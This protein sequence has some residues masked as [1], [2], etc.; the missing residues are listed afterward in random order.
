M[1]SE[2]IYYG[3]LVVGVSLVCWEVLQILDYLE[4]KIWAWRR[5]RI[6]RAWLTELERIKNLDPTFKRCNGCG[7]RHL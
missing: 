2:W 5:G 1:S 3:V 4:R 7:L 6:D